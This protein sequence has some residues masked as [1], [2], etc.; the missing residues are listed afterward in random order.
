MFD[1]FVALR[2]V[3]DVYYETFAI[4]KRFRQDVPSKLF[5]VFDFGTRSRAD[6]P[7]SQKAV[8]HFNR[9][10]SVKNIIT[11][12]IIVIIIYRRIR[13]CPRPSELYCNNMRVVFCFYHSSID[14]FIYRSNT[15]REDLS[16][17]PITYR[18]YIQYIRTVII[19]TVIVHVRLTRFKYRFVFSSF[20]TPP[21][22]CIGIHP[23][24]IPKSN[25]HIYIY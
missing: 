15:L 6:A 5:R 25:F 11:I 8:Y 4:S 16:S 18:T 1:D 17:T 22:T 7:I 12:L 21:L 20:S 10:I 19:I 9:V 2:P 23:W 3:V 13:S 24:S 14:L